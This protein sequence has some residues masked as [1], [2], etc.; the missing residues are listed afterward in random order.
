[1]AGLDIHATD[2]HVDSLLF[3]RDG[4]AKGD[5]LCVVGGEGE[6]RMP[7]VT[8]VAEGLRGRLSY[9]VVCSTSMTVIKSLSSKSYNS[10]SVCANVSSRPTSIGS[11]DMTRAGKTGG[12]DSGASRSQDPAGE[13]D[14]RGIQHRC[15]RAKVAR[16]SFQSPY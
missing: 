13:Q 9:E 10:Y 6:G 1:M 8:L 4:V 16:N 2:I 15:G 7:C 14:Q 5:G 12:L 3:L 11:A